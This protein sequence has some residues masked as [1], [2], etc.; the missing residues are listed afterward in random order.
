MD[1][2]YRIGQDRPVFVYQLICKGSVLEYVATS[3][4]QKKDIA[5]TLTDDINCVICKNGLVCVANG[6]RPFTEKCL[7]KTKTAR[8]IIKPKKL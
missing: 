4:D 1:R 2:N 7:Y 6:I 8:V 3:L 5:A